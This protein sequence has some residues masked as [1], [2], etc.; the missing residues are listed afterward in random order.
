MNIAITITILVCCTLLISVVMLRYIMSYAYHNHYFDGHDE[1]K[2]HHGDVPRLGGL[3]FVPAMVLSLILV[4]VIDDFF[5]TG[6]IL[7]ELNDNPIK[8]MGLLLSVLVLMSF[9]IMDDLRDL[10]YRIKFGSQII[11]ALI[12]CF[13]G[14]WIDNLH[15]A[16]GLYE[17]SPWLGF[18]ITIFVL[19]FVINAINFIDGI[20]G[21]SASLSIIALGFY[22]YVFG[23][24]QYSIM[25]VLISISL[26]VCL[27]SYLYFNLRG[28]PERKNKIFMGDTGSTFLGLI[29]A[30][31]GME[32][33]RAADQGALLMDSNALIVGFAP[34]TL[35]CYDVLRVVLHRLK[36]RK[37]PFA[38]DNNHLHHKLLACGMS[39]NV[40]LC[41]IIVISITLISIMV[42]L[43]IKLNINLVLV[44][45]LALWIV[46]NIIIT[47]QM[48]NK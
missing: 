4:T 47:K 25:M 11:S 16:F 23:V 28:K 45:S 17:L 12:L 24:K 31:M 8:I 26:M 41:T 10:K 33:T 3:M 35:P 1:R 39:Q 2:I 32:A 43:G 37:S 19:I 27:S 48:K 30:V 5:G 44:I 46:F 9:G 13:C 6:A 15:G 38:A 14:V 18:P 20:D 29:L 21:L 42:L 22:A 34:L 40:T 36:N 7:Q